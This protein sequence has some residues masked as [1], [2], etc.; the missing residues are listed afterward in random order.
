M[1][2]KSDRRKLHTKS[3]FCRQTKIDANTRL[4]F[5]PNTIVVFICLLP[6]LNKI[7]LR[8]LVKG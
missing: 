2:H 5:T 3:K 6:Y 7:M 1:V 8:H 4:T